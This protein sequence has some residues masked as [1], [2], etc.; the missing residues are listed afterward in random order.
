MNWLFEK[1]IHHTSLPNSLFHLS[2]LFD[3]LDTSLLFCPLSWVCWVICILS[4]MVLFSKAPQ[5]LSCGS[6]SLSLSFLESQ[7]ACLAIEILTLDFWAYLIS[8]ICPSKMLQGCL[9]L[10]CTWI[11]LFAF[12]KLIGESSALILFIYVKNTCTHISFSYFSFYKLVSS[13]W[14]N[15]EHK[16][17]L[18]WS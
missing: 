8:W 14:P 18:K 13:L 11:C 17:L 5:K 10:R 15:C 16:A 1:P 7:P 2:S 9:V 3:K 12:N 4:E 6:H